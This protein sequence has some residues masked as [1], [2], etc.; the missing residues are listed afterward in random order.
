MFETPQALYLLE[1][2]IFGSVVF[3][4]LSRKSDMAVVLYVVQSLAV[5]TLLYG[6]SVF[7][8]SAILLVAALATLA[9][10]VIFAPYFFH[11]LIG[12]HHLTFSA[13]SYVSM[14]VTLAILAIVTAVA[15][16]PYFAPLAA[17]APENGKAL[18]LAFAAMGL[19]LFLAVNRKGVLSQMIGILSMENALV[20]FAFIAGL[21]Q[22]ASLQIAVLF[23]ITVWVAIAGIFASMIYGHFGTSDAAAAMHTLTED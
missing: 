13:S 23:D 10:K 14:P 18:L 6:S 4:H 15:Y 17:L 20:S 21:E 22:A 9:V 3:M 1:M 8:F 16:S 7:S 5:V 11:R 12:K 19:S 2:L